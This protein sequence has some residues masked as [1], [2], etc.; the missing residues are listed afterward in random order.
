M[1][2][3]IFATLGIIS[4]VALP[5]VGTLVAHADVPDPTAFGLM[6]ASSTNTGADYVTNTIF[7]GGVLKYLLFIGILAVVIWFVKTGLHK[8]VG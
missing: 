1:K 7:N 3:K 4:A 8:L 5:V 2:A 6:A